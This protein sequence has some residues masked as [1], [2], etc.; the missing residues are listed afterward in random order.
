MR[1][2]DSRRLHQLFSMNVGRRALRSRRLH[3][4]STATRLMSVP[5]S[6]NRIAWSSTVGLRCMW[7]AADEQAGVQH[8][9]RQEASLTLCET[10]RD[11]DLSGLDCRPVGLQHIC[12]WWHSQTLP[13]G[14]DVRCTERRK[15]GV[16]SQVWECRDCGGENSV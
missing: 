5:V 1:G 13:V 10:E 14:D 3:C 16:S 9:S 7:L 6:N 15:L 8:D 11:E 2:F 12:R 4:F